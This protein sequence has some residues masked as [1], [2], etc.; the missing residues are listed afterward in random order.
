MLCR[1]L[2][3]LSVSMHDSLSSIPSLTCSY[4]LHSMQ[5]VYFIA[6][7]QTPLNPPVLDTVLDK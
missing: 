5:A 4:M 3:L 6:L 7:N 1:Q 2:V